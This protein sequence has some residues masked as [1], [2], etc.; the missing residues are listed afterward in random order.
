[1][2]TSPKRWSYDLERLYEDQEPDFVIDVIAQLICWLDPVG[3]QCEHAFEVREITRR[4]PVEHRLDLSW[5][6]R[7]LARRDPRLEADLARFRSGKTLTKE[8]QAKYAAYGLAFVATS[9]LL[10]RRI[11]EVAYFRSPD[12]LLD[13]TPDALKGV[14]VAGRGSRGYAALEQT[15]RGAKG[16][17][18]K[19]AQ[20]VQRAD[21]K[22]AY[23]SLWCCEPRVAVWQKVKP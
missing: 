9:C 2:S 13:A 11:E 17:V 12:L 20:L 21:V 16:K 4:G 1:M 3:D 23:L 5:N 14:E 18:G 22:E 15:L 10:R 6:V 7:R 8:D 19:H